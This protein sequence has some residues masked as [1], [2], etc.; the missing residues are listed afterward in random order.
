[1]T[2]LR[3]RKPLCAVVEL[4]KE[5]RP[6]IDTRSAAHHLMRCEQTLRAWSCLENGPLQPIRVHRRLFWKTDE[7]RRLL[8]VNV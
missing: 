1:M 2:K 5:T 7:I 6:M 4:D 8:G 3:N